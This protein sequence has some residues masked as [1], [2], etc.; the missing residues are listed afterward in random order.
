MFTLRHLKWFAVDF[1]EQVQNIEKSKALIVEVVVF[2]HCEGKD[3]RDNQMHISS[4]VKSA[5]RKFNEGKIMAVQVLCFT[6]G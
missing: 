4:Q 5:L 1:I 2:L 6:S 3:S